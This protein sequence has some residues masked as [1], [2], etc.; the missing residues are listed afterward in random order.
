MKWGRARYG[1]PVTVY[2]WLIGTAGISLLVYC[3]LKRP[4]PQQP[5]P[6]TAFL[7]FFAMHVVASFLHF[8]YARLNVVITFESSFTTATLLVFGSLPAALVSVTG[9]V[10]GSV[11]R[12][13]Q[14]RY[15]LHKN[16]PLAYDM[17][18]I[19]FNS[20]MVSI[21]WL[22]ASW[23]YISL[24]HGQLPLVALNAHSIL[25]IVV[26]FLSLSFIN[27]I[28][29]FLSCYFQAMDSLL[30]FKRAL[31]PAFFTEFAAIPFG[32]VMALSYTR[33][34]LLAFLFLGITLLLSNAV[35]RN[36][37]LIRYDQEEKLRQL[38]ALNN[39]SRDIISLRSEGAV[40]ALL[41]QETGMIL[42]N[43]QLFLVRTDPSTKKLQ[44]LTRDVE[45]ASPLLDLARE[46]A[47]SKQGILITN[48]RKDC[49]AGWR[50][51]LGKELIRSL[52]AV[53]MCAGD[54]VYGVLGAYS[55]EACAL[56]REHMQVLTMIAHE[57]ALALENA[58]LYGA[59]KDQV[60]ELERLNKELRQLDKLKSQ[61]LANV[62]HEL[63]T[64]LTS[65]KGYVDY[66]HK[67][68]LGPITTLQNEGLTVAQ[69][70]ISRLQKLINDLLDYTKL[71][72]RR[73]SLALS[74]CL[75]EDVWKEAFDDSAESIERKRL[76]FQLRV[77]S[78]LP[79][80]FLDRSKF[81]Q[82]MSNLLT[83]AVKFTPEEGC[84]SVDLSCMAHHPNFYNL[85]TYRNSCI[86]ESLIPVRITIR[87]TG[88][89]I[90]PE[91]IGRI[92]DRFYQVDSSNTRK[93]GGTGLGLALVKSIL[94]AHG[95]PIGVQSKV[96]EGTEFTIVVPGIQRDEIPTSIKEEHLQGHIQPKYLT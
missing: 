72:Y 64:P 68:K 89:G 82:V 61:F 53:P 7:L 33:M 11:K 45:E 15:V 83:N 5:I 86:L 23:V 3:I 58:K 93:Y 13:I 18:I 51:A 95:S 62:S 63:R 42:D 88:I 73:T 47:A 26:M 94:D 43:S 32:V 75:F 66:I 31:M 27:H 21:M 48:A 74:P 29:L 67:E 57:G 90:P 40:I 54:A 8:Q 35:L 37:S 39:I 65:I 14:R 55:K 56:K 38:R 84:I 50:E 52:V 96:G 9:I 41:F 17:G 70:N 85:E 81:I 36:L 76:R 77:P 24:L 92:F 25:F 60:S 71:E 28:C 30:F 49:P 4:F 87:D 19:V 69:R 78:E 80:L 2:H 20:G 16:I 46:V 12:I 22:S 10:F 59:L 91:A 44:L 6:V 1:L 34:G 79:L